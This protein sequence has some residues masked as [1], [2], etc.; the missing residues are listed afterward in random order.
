MKRPPMRVSR[1]QGEDR[2]Q[3]YHYH[4]QPGMSIP[5]WAVAVLVSLGV[6]AGGFLISWGTLSNRIDVLEAAGFEI[7]VELKAKTAERSTQM[8]AVGR[9]IEALQKDSERVIRLE[10][11]LAAIQETLV[12][13]DAAL[14]GPR[15]SANPRRPLSNGIQR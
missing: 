13:I 4:A 9:R 10:E 11:K 3:E 14:S 7:K 2:L 12:R 5:A 15:L 1:T 8:E 6:T